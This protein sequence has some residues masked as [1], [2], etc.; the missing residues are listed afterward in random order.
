MRAKKELAL[1]SVLKV[2]K[3]ERKEFLDTID[4]LNEKVEEK[5]LEIGQIEEM[6]E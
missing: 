4:S 3:E 6:L 5:E 1:R 2:L